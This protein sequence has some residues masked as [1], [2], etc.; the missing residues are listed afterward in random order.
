MKLRN[1]VL[2]ERLLESDDFSEPTLEEYPGLQYPLFFPHDNKGN[3]IETPNPYVKTLFK[4]LLDKIDIESRGTLIKNFGFN[5]N[6][7]EAV[8]EEKNFSNKLI[9]RLNLQYNDRVNWNNITRE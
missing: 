1:K 3:I 6:E 5:M 2:D 4:D 8:M 7:I 9:D